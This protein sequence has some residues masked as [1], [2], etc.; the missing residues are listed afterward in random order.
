MSTEGPQRPEQPE[1]PEHDDV[2]ARRRFPLVV[3]SVA[4]AVLLAGGGGAYLATS[5]SGGGD[6]DRA[7]SGGPSADASPPP[8]DLD[9]H[10]EGGTEPDAPGIAPGEP[11][12]SGARYRLGDKV[13]DGLDEP[14]AAPVYRPR[15]EVT[16]DQVA[17]L[18]AALK[19]KGTPR[20]DGTA[21]KVGPVKGGSGHELQVHKQAPGSWTYTQ[22]FSGE[23]PA[24]APCAP[25]G[26]QGLGSQIG[27]L[28][29]EEAK[30]A[31]RPLLKA[32]GQDDAKLDARQTQG[33]I[34]V[35]NAD[36]VVGGLPTHGWSTSVQVSR[37]GALVGA[38]GQLADLTKG[39]TY[40][41]LGV[42]ETL[43]RLNAPAKGA[44]SRGA[45]AG[46]ASAVPHDGDKEPLDQQA[47]CEPGSDMPV[48]PKPT[49]VPVR[50][51]VFGLA[52]HFERGRQVLVPSW[53]FTVKPYGTEEAVTITHPAVDPAHLK[54]PATAKPTPEPEHRSQAIEAYSADGKTLTL[55]FWGGVCSTYSASAEERGD[56]VVV[57]ITETR[58]DPG[59]VCILIA[60]ELTEPVTLDKP[61]GDREVVDED[62]EPVRRA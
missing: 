57:K 45:I 51:A 13:T 11:D 8:L 59:R 24:R 62:G 61:L 27:P 40:P 33:R 44:A 3:T 22:Y 21:W 6:G 55:H 10:T 39:A 52:A 9:G 34:R 58:Q 36:P 30:A 7:G 23:C 17:R 28:S 1:R 4:A 48:Q 26:G 32:I 54:A 46:C 5:A 37:S 19:V 41:V 47:P 31:A 56:R 43:K 15:G 50:D 16:K 38:S 49:T 2:P 42:E 14:D 53:L 18:A 12:P 60:K 20:L 35:V 25:V 29:E